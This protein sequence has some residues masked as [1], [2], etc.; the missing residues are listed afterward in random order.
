M[1]NCF[2]SF[3]FLGF[4]CKHFEIVGVGANE[5]NGVNRSIKQTRISAGAVR[6]AR[7][8][9]SQQIEMNFHF[10]V[11]V[12]SFTLVVVAV[13]VVGVIIFKT[14]KCKMFLCFMTE[15]FGTVY[16][17]CVFM[18]QTSVTRDRH[19]LTFVLFSISVQRDR[20]QRKK[21]GQKSE[22]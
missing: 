9:K 12:S 8:R 3:F 7:A 21:K 5:T 13:V 11:R 16:Y 4:G 6:R 1:N 19:P 22:T 17:S 14:R 2:A 20:E 10:V 18:G 15:L